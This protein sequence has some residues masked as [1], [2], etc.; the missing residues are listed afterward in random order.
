MAEIKDGEEKVLNLRPCIGRGF[1]AEL[2][3][4]EKF[5]KAFIEPGGGIA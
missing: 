1:T 3:N 2:L 5:Q 4:K